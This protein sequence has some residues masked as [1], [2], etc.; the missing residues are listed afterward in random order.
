MG[1]AQVSGQVNLVVAIKLRGQRLRHAKTD[2]TLLQGLQ[3]QLCELQS[4]L[5]IVLATLGLTATPPQL[6]QAAGRGHRVS[7]TR[8]QQG[9]GEG[10]LSET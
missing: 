10:A 6:A 4:D 7:H 8:G 5:V 9:Q 2:P 3:L 1:G